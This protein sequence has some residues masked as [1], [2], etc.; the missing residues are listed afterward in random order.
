MSTLFKNISLPGT[1]VTPGGVGVPYTPNSPEGATSTFSRR[2]AE[3]TVRHCS[4]KTLKP[5]V[6]IIFPST[7]IKSRGHIVLFIEKSTTICGQL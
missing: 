6:F 5:I 4:H 7:N 3:H 1:P 2:L